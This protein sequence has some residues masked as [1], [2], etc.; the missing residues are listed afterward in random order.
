MIMDPACTECDCICVHVCT[1]TVH[2]MSVSDALRFFEPPPPPPPP[3]GPSRVLNLVDLHPIWGVT[4]N[5][6]DRIITSGRC[7]QIVRMFESFT[8]KQT[9]TLA[10]RDAI[11]LKPGVISTT[12]RNPLMASYTDVT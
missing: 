12:H 5:D 1:P 4:D 7:R 10:S 2:I 6:L 8:L 9:P 3:A 11:T